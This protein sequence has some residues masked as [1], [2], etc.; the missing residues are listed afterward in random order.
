M[1][2]LSMFRLPVLFFIVLTSIAGS[3]FGQGNQTVVTF[4]KSI[5]TTLKLNYL[6]S[7]PEGSESL[8]LDQGSQGLV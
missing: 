7:L 8:G 1:L 6:L 5:E 2:Y 3:V 4:E